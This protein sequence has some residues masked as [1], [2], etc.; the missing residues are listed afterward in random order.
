VVLVRLPD[1]YYSDEFV[2]LYHGRMEDVLPQ[3]G[4]F[5][6]CVTDPPYGETTL[7]WD[8]WPHKWPCLVAMLAAS[9]WCFG[10]LKLIAQRWAEFE[11]AEWT[12]SQDVVWEKH[13]GSGF[14]KDR[15]RRVH[16]HA[17]LWYQ[18]A[19]SEVRHEVPR[20]PREGRN[21]G[22]RRARVQTPHTGRTNDAAAWCDDGTRL[23]R[24]V[25]YAPSMKGRAIHP[26]EKPVAVLRP[27]IEYSVPEGGLVL[28]PFAGSGSTLAAAR[29]LGRRSIG[30]EADEE[31][32]ERAAERL[33]VPDLFGGVA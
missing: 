19:W 30:V 13:N 24:S 12:Y 6:A 14:A 1:P 17:T 29:E 15:F 8:S 9:L 27:L 10:S 16:E 32:C 18:G 7:E 2:T 11:L 3:L 22:T 31:Y 4:G 23:Q 21:Q 20:V 28:D 33:S 25:I 26:T 5:D